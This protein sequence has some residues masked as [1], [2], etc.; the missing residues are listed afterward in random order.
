M[1]QPSKAPKMDFS[2]KTRNTR[3]N[4]FICQKRIDSD[5]F[6]I[7]Y[8]L[9]NIDY[10]FPYT[11]FVDWFK[12]D[13]PIYKINILHLGS[14]SLGVS[15]SQLYFPSS[16]SYS[17][18]YFLVGLCYHFPVIVYQQLN[19]LRLSPSLY[20]LHFLLANK[21]SKNTTTYFFLIVD[22]L[23]EPFLFQKMKRCI[24]WF[25]LWDGTFAMNDLKIINT[26]LEWKIFTMVIKKTGWC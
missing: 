9:F 19:K 11:I 23:Y 7:C 6:W 24:K 21:K 20:T 4:Q 5:L 13:W 15:C 22:Y 3:N 10:L 2:T 16:N 1:S 26:L 18:V 25:V 8:A 17:F 14:S 12:V